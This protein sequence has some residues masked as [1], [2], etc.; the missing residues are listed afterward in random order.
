MI[1][2]DFA[3]L[4]DYAIDRG[5]VI[6][7]QGVGLDTLMAN[8][9]PVAHPQLFL[10]AQFRCPVEE[11]GRKDLA[12]RLKDDQGKVIMEQKGEATF[13]PPPHGRWSLARLVIGFHMLQFHRFGRNHFEI[14]LGKVEISRLPL[15]IVPT[16]NPGMN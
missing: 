10:V 7:A 13:V 12:I 14:Q 15:N 11:L 2:C 4:A 9:V 3:F 1:T 8:S 5:G 6:N 16:G